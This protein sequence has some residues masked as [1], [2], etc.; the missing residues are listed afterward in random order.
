MEVQRKSEQETP[1]LHNIE[2]DIY[3]QRIAEYVQMY[4]KPG[5]LLWINFLIGVFRGVGMAVGFTVLGAV[6]IYILKKLVV[7]NIPLIGNFI[8]EIAKIVQQHL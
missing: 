2:R 7:L 6:L 8:A 3:S 4:A 1:L 5:K